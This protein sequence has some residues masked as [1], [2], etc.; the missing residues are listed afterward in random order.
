MRR[1]GLGFTFI[2]VLMGVTLSTTVLGAAWAVFN[3]S[4]RSQGATDRRGAM[5][6]ARIP[7][8]S[9]ARCGRG[10]WHTIWWA[11]VLEDEE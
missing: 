11:V 4:N 8:G 1:R 7:A 3:L 9:P 5:V 10:R 2:E 6:R